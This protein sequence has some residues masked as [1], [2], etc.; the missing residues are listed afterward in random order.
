MPSNF[1]G[2]ACPKP[3]PR[4]KV[5]ARATR[6]ART[7]V[8]DVRAAVVERDGMCRVPARLGPCQGVLEWAHM[9]SHRRSKTRGQP[10][11]D[12]HTSEGTLMLCSFHHLQYDVHA[13]RIEPL[14]DQG[15]NGELKFER[16]A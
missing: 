11:E 15:A 3:E 1:G 5:K 8:K 16:G 14:T 13:L 6:Q 12:R 7:V 9:H 4:K 10:A 2:T